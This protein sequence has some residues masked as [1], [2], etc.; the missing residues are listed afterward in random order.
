MGNVVCTD[1]G[2]LYVGVRQKIVG[3]LAFGA[4]FQICQDGRVL[5]LMPVKPCCVFLNRLLDQ[6]LFR[7]G[8]L[9]LDTDVVEQP[10][11]QLFC[12]FGGFSCQASTIFA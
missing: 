7:N 10:L 1:N 11:F 5:L 6:T 2:R 8:F 4:A 3:M 9:E 12:G